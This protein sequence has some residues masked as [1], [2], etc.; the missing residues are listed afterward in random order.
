MFVIWWL[1]V[2]NIL[3]PANQTLHLIQLCFF[4][5]VCVLILRLPI[6]R[7]W[8]VRKWCSQIGKIQIMKK[9]NDKDDDD[10][11]RKRKITEKNGSFLQSHISYVFLIQISPSIKHTHSLTCSL[12]HAHKLW[13]I[14]NIYLNS[15]SLWICPVK[16]GVHLLVP[17]LMIQSIRSVAIHLC[18]YLCVRSF[19][20][21]I[22][23]QNKQ[24]NKSESK[25]KI[26]ISCYQFYGIHQ[27]N[28]AGGGW[29]VGWLMRRNRKREKVSRS[30]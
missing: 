9:G 26:K 27:D 25:E 20:Y 1:S 5:A 8:C 12:A 19:L 18:V 6:H 11:R 10:R 16:V 29:L 14:N 7:Q 2:Y 22:H 17:H 4:P 15:N 30:Y 21:K 23:A 13:L 24:T 28:R 3:Q